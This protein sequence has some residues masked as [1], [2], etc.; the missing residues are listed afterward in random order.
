MKTKAFIFI[1]QIGIILFIFLNFNET[2]GQGF[3]DWSDKFPLTD[4]VTDNVNP[5]MVIIYNGNQE[6]L[7]M[8]WEK[9]VNTSSSAI[10]YDDLLTPDEPQ[11]LVSEPGV[12]FTHPKILEVNGDEFLFYVFYQSDQN[13]NQD[14]YFM[15]YGTDGLFTGPFPFATAEFDEQEFATDND[16]YFKKSSQSRYVVSSFAWTS[17]GELFTS[18]L[19]NN[20]NVYTFTDPVL[21]D[22]GTCTNPVVVTNQMIY[23]IR[24]DD[25]GS[26]IYVVYKQT[27]LG[28]WTEPE[29]Y[30]NEGNCFNLAEDNVTPQYLAWSADSNGVFRSYMANSYWDYNGYAL[31]PESDTP[32]DPAV[33]TVVIGVAP[34]HDQ[35][36]DY[37]LAFPYLEDGYE[38]IFMNE[39]WGGEDFMNFSQSNTENHNPEFFIGESYN[40][41]WCFYVYLTWEEFRNNHWQIFCAK[42]IMCYGGVDE[43]G[44]NDSFFKTFPNPFTDEVAVSYSLL[45]DEVINIEVVDL[46]GRIISELYNGK[47][48]AGKHEIQ[49]NG[50]EAPPGLYFIRFSSDRFSSSTRVLKID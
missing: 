31:G 24:E 26:F 37:Y 38:E 15:K 5:H 22:G 10:Y 8:V 45:S 44:S 29:I 2:R 35:F 39:D 49:W 18:D 20:G 9:S 6:L 23:Y 32:L 21:I 1:L 42:T 14:I 11:A 4:S 41:E 34:E 13:G 12:H 50:K 33:C 27:S 36:M 3:Y 30:F 17:G 40:Y 28:T 47:Q 25:S 19:E 7:N 46:Y 48:L 16:P 43:N